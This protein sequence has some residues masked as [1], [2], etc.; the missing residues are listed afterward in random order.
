[1]QLLEKKIDEELLLLIA[2]TSIIQLNNHP[3][4]IP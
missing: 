1:M 3:L 4:I 2:H